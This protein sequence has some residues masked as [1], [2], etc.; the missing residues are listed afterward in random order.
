M[1]ELSRS[2]DEIQQSVEDG[3]NRMDEMLPKD[4]SD[5]AGRWVAIRDGI[6]VASGENV[7]DLFQQEAVL[8]TDIIMT[9]PEPCD[10]FL[11]AA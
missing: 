1:E 3:Q 7:D 2:P 4:L 6:V 9:V 8:P 5:Y 11:R 10:Q